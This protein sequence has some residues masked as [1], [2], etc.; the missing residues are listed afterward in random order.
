MERAF[1]SSSSISCTFRNVIARSYNSPSAPVLNI[2]T[3]EDPARGPVR[4]ECIRCV[5]SDTFRTWEFFP[6]HPRHDATPR[7][8][9]RQE[10]REQ[11]E[12]TRTEVAVPYPA[13]LCI[14]S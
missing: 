5:Q 7:A 14:C 2:V 10:R 13:N 4:Q 8:E 9:K 12:D 6:A 3:Q 1:P 11:H